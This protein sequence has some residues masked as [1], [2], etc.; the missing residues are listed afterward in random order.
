MFLR[1]I[2]LSFRD[3]N[4]HKTFDRGMVIGLF[5]CVT[6]CIV[7]FFVSEYIMNFMWPQRGLRQSTQI[8]GKANY[9]DFLLKISFITVL[10]APL[11]FLSLDSPLELLPALPYLFLALVTD[12]QP[13]FTVTWQYPALIS[14]PFFIAALIGASHQ[15]SKKIGI[16]LL[17]AIIIFA[18]ILSPGSP[19]MSQFS[20][21]WSIYVPN[22]EI[23]L[24]HEALTN[25]EPNATV[26]AQENIFPNVAERK[27]VYSY[28]PSNLEPP[29]YIVVDVLDTWFYRDPAEEKTMDA[30]L[31]YVNTFNYG[32][33]TT[34]NGF[35]ILKK[36]F[37]GSRNVMMPMHISLEFDQL[38]KPFVAF[39]DY[40][41]ETHFYVPDWVEVKEDHLFLDRSNLGNAWWGPWITV[42]PGKYKMEVQFSAEE[43]TDGAILGLSVYWWKHQTYAEKIVQGSE[44]VP[45]Q[46][47]TITV[48]FELNEWVPALEIVGTAFGKTNINVYS[49]SMQET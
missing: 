4:S 10:T 19:L 42:P 33:S 17:A 23:F 5:A 39:E 16:K 48:E 37:Q 44:V 1:E 40:F 46:R 7:Y 15:F 8:F 24:K 41:M 9:N 47:N 35:M 32:I 11:A 36:D 25:I 28:W 14:I 31:R 22:Q 45:G 13:Y 30:L 20:T 38:H 18:F 21:G 26:L 27:V 12:Y 34:V 43:A 2:Y 3:R 49:I 29:D 6:I